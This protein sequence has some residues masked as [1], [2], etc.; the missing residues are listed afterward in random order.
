MYSLVRLGTKFTSLSLTLALFAAS[1]TTTASAQSAD[2]L[3]KKLANP[4]ASMISVPIQQNFDF[5]GGPNKN[6]FVSTTNIQPVIP[7]ALGPNWNLIVRTILPIVHQ[8]RIQPTHES[9]LSD[10][11]QSFF[12]SPSKPGPGG[13]VW[14]VGPVFLY[15]TATNNKLGGQKW[16]AGPTAVALV[17][18]GKW[19]LGALVNHIWSFAGSSNRQNIS[20]TFLQPFVSYA[21]GGGLSIGANTEATYDWVNKTW[22]VPVNLSVNKLFKVGKQ[23]IQFSIGPKYYIARPNGGSRWGVRATLTFL[24]PK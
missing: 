22:N 14:G 24:F 3:A 9:G 8:E 11:S 20:R 13:L 6:G 10:I 7:I 16:G 1:S 19:T 2:E 17:Q 23:P 18:K 15:P 5:N 4:I 12:F 21:L